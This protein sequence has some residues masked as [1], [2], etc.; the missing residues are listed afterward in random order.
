MEELFYDLY[1]SQP[2][3]SAFAR[4]LHFRPK[5]KKFI[6]HHPYFSGIY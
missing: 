4:T 3:Y 1:D 5:A 2:L 6:N